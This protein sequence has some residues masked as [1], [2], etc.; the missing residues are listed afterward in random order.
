M[1]TR[2]SFLQYSN[3]PYNFPKN[4]FY[5]NTRQTIFVQCSILHSSL[6]TLGTPQWRRHGEMSHGL[7]LQLDLM[8]IF[9]MVEE[10]DCICLV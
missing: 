5:N 7:A 3:R 8:G 1:S 9:S 4:I 2:S 6:T 10:L